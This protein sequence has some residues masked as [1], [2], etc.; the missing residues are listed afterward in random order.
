MTGG[1]HP[2]LLL[3]LGT[4]ELPPRA[5]PQLGRD[6]ASGLRDCLREA[7]LLA[8][9]AAAPQ[10]FAAPRRLAALVPGV[11]ARQESRATERRGPLLSA[12]FDK[13]G[14]P[15]AAAAGFARS[16]G[17]AVDAL[18]AV[19]EGEAARLVHRATRPGEDLAVLVPQCIAKALRALPVPKRM[20]WG[21]GET[22]FVRPVHWVVLL[23]GAAVIPARILSVQSGG[24]TRGHRVHANRAITVKHADDYAEV[25]LAQGK[26]I[27]DFAARKKRIAEQVKAIAKKENAAAQLDEDLLDE[28]TG[29]VEWPQAVAGAIDAEFM[30]VPEEALVCSMRDHQKYFP[31]RDSGGKLLPR[32]VLVSNIESTAPAGMENVR[33]GNERVLRARLAD[34]RFFWDSDRKTKLADRA[35]QLSGIVF[36]QKLGTIADKSKRVAG[37]ARAL[38]PAFGADKKTVARAA[39]LAKADLVTAMVGEFPSL[40]GVMGR[41]YALADGEPQA[42]A[43]A[44][45]EHYLPRFAGDDLPQSAAGETLA[46]ADRLDTLGGIFFAGDAPSGDKDPY[47]LRRA[48]LGV[49]RILIENG[50]DL[51]LLP[52]LERAA[53]QHNKTA[54]KKTARQVL[55]FILERLRAYS[56]AR[57][58]AAA[59]FLAVRAVAAQNPLDFYRRLEAVARF[60][61]LPAAQNLAAAN[62]RI[63]NI[64]QQA[65]IKTAG[66]VDKKLLRE[67]AEKNLF[68]AL[69][70]ISKAAKKDFTAA[71]YAEALARAAE[72]QAPVD[73]F[74][75]R[76]MVMADDAALRKNR[77]ALLAEVRA[78]CNGVADISRLAAG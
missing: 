29:L 64:L 59:E 76:V 66:A 75:D 68:A 71:R 26:V 20:R 21:G 73:A 40:Q 74:F 50:R 67:D 54:A 55:D 51:D 37:L 42:V 32:F 57:G 7:R 14:K 35:A 24:T 78:L 36:H 44:V 65:K 77:L 9:E 61:K 48:A 8:D 6:L 45:A 69:G 62:K 11:R 17:V 39:A 19:G 41:R 12:A 63:A 52:W 16:C 30:S 46:V 22:E 10:W 31:L 3:E 5:L 56:T 18:A 34:A 43:E 70:K 28:V 2:S 49:L 13:D 53:A 25:L 33:R 15:T 4:E 47:A 27:A 23:H 58:F 38:A 60:R 72:L 1:G